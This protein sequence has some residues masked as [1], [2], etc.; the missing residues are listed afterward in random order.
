MFWGVT[1][2]LVETETEDIT[3]LDHQKLNE[4]K[5]DLELKNG[6][7]IVITHGDGKYFQHGF[8]NSI[9]V[10]TIR[11]HLEDAKKKNDVDKVDFGKG[12]I[13]LDTNACAGCQNCV[14][15]C[16]HDIYKVGENRE[17]YI[18]SIKCQRMH[19]RL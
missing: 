8:S 17:T 10:E 5:K 11:E 12:S 18:D 13:I 1:P 19:F 9:R 6:D 16:P 4:I 2:Y 7:K 15:V 14:S 3:F